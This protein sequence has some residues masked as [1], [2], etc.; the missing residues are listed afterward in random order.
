MLAQFAPGFEAQGRAGPASSP[1]RPRRVQLDADA[2]SQMLGNL[3]GNVEKYAPEAK[4]WWRR[5]PRD[6]A[7]PSPCRTA[8]PAFPGRTGERIFR[9]FVRLGGAAHEGVPGTGI[10]LG[11]ARDLARLHGGDLRVLPV[12]RAAPAS[13]SR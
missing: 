1:G 2:L 11:L 8:G 9:P 4:W 13:S 6:R 5:R 10:G 12:R 7:S 3:L